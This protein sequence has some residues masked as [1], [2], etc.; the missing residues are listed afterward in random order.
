MLPDGF[1]E[2]REAVIWAILVVDHQESFYLSLGQ[3]CA[4]IIS[5]LVT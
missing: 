1:L 2:L 4:A 3:Q 5:S